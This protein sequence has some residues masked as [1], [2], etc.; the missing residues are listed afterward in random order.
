VTIYGT[1]WN[2]PE[3]CASIVTD[4][5]NAGS[6]ENL[7]EYAGAMPETAIKEIATG[8]LNSL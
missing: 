1:Y 4:Y 5:M 8:V 6:I 3:G 2:V 7:L